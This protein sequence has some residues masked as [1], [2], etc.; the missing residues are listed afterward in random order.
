[1]HR[2]RFL[3]GTVTAAAVTA[4]CLG[5]GSPSGSGGNGDGYPSEDAVES[6]PAEREVDDSAFSTIT[7]NGEP[8]TLVPVEVAHYWW[9][10]REARFAD[11]RGQEQYDT[12][13]V[14]GAVLSPAGADWANDP[15][16]AWS[17]E[18]RIVCYCGCPHHLSSIRAAAL[19]Q[20]GYE[21]VYVIDEGFWEWHKRGFSV[22]GED[23][24]WAPYESWEITGE[25]DPRHAGDYAWAVHE[26][27]SQQ[28]AA[29]IES[30]G[31][32]TLDVKFGDVTD[33]TPITLRTPAWTISAPLGTL[34][35]GVVTTPN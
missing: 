29:P 26:P 11:A 21:R 17:T 8:I 22:T 19:Q 34:A 9:G 14:T 3:A 7:T 25:V 10:R 6:P 16:T 32:F 2:R 12:S 15:V 31:E 18:D 5:G 30:S 4:G 23:P 13:H 28:E 27:S 33:S 24:D 35:G 1:M 20:D